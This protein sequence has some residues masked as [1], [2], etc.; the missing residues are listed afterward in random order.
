M[1]RAHVRWGSG[2]WIAQLPPSPPPRQRDSSRVFHVP[3]QQQLSSV[4]PGP[5]A[6]TS[7][8]NSPETQM[9]GPYCGPTRMDGAQQV[10]DTLKLRTTAPTETPIPHPRITVGAFFFCPVFT[11]QLP[12]TPLHPSKS[13][14]HSKHRR[15]PSSILKSLLIT[16][17]NVFLSSF[18]LQQNLLSVPLPQHTLK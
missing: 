2:S 5:A 17:A 13:Y 15:S 8:G 12:A 16:P 4:A 18:E 1:N 14:L 6:A 7:P 11:G 9:Q 10:T 3:L